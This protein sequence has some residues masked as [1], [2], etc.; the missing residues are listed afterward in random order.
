MQL[1][2]E[3]ALRA[4]LIKR[5]PK[6][7]VPLLSPVEQLEEYLLD[8]SNVPR[9]GRLI[10][11]EIENLSERIRAISASDTARDQTPDGVFKLMQAYENAASDMLE[12]YVRACHNDDGS[13]TQTLVKA[14]NALAHTTPLNHSVGK[15]HLYPVLLLLYAGGIAAIAGKRF[16]TLVALLR[17]VKIRTVDNARG[18]SAAYQLNPYRVIGES[19]AKYLPPVRANYTP[20]STYFFSL[21]RETLCS[22]PLK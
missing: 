9:A 20:I 7:V 12:L 11:S 19:I 10:E 14:L 13:L 6:P 3:N 5:T 8:A 17:D 16:S 4:W 21:L 18:S 1:D 2:F 15:P 22:E